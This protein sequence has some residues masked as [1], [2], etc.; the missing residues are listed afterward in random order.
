MR[1]VHNVLIA[2]YDSNGYSCLMPSY[3]DP[4]FRPTLWP[5]TVVPTPP[6]RPF[7]SAE[8]DGDWIVWSP[9]TAWQSEP[10][11]LPA[12]FYMRELLELQADDLEAAAGL[13]RSHGNLFDFDRE[14]LNL[15]SYDDDYVAKIDAIPENPE[16]MRGGV[17]RGL[18]KL[19]IETAQDAIRAWLAC[20]REGGLH[21]LVAQ[22]VTEE[23]RSALKDSSGHIVASTLDELE[24]LL[25]DVRLSDLETVINAALGK[26]SIGV[27]EL[28]HRWPTIYSVSFLQLYNHMVEGAAAHRCASETCQRLF[29]RQRGR[30]EY[31]Q[32]R[33]EGVKYCSREC[34]RAQAQRELR[35]RRKAR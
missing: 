3:I 22:D 19:H 23:Y 2:Y 25:I 16:G 29:V 18:V 21:E 24:D 27:R 1:V 32:Y 14:E 28:A 15:K 11:Q 9:G 26:F 34:A 4:R 17:H 8:V 31:G 7:A 35:R 6:L 30:S 5:G 10:V 13:Y 12:D 20:Q 33:T